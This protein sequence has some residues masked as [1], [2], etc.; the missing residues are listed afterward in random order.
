MRQ[1]GVYI[2]VS[3]CGHRISTTQYQFVRPAAPLF[4]AHPLLG[5]HLGDNL[6]RGREDD[7]LLQRGTLVAMEVVAHNHRYA[8]FRCVGDVE[9]EQRLMR[10]AV[11][12]REFE[13][14]LLLCGEAAESVGVLRH[15]LVLHLNARVLRRD[16]VLQ[17]AEHAQQLGPPLALPLL[18]VLHSSAVGAPQHVWQL[19]CRHQT[20]IVVH[21]RFF[22]LSRCRGAHSGGQQP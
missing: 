10:L 15:Q 8:A 14:H 7:I 22:V 12:S 1:V 18:R 17:F 6:L 4:S 9:Q 11:R 16:A 20:L 3:H 5:T 19:V 2:V 21:R 13:E